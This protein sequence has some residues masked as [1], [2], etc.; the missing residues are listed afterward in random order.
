MS[1]G[2]TIQPIDNQ[3]QSQGNKYT[4]PEKNFSQKF[5]NCERCRLMRGEVRKTS[6]KVAFTLAEI[7]ITL[8]IIGVVAALTL[9]SVI[10]NYNERVTISKLK[11]LNST[12]QNSFNLMHQE[13][14]GGLDVSQWGYISRD[15]FVQ[16]YTKYMNVSKVCTKSNIYE[17]VPI[18]VY[19]NLGGTKVSLGL[20]SVSSG[21]VLNDGATAALV[22]F[23]ES[24]PGHIEATGVYGQIFV[25]VNGKNPPNVLGRDAFSFVF[26]KEG[27][28]PNGIVNLGGYGSS[29]YDKT[30]FCNK[31][32][33]GAGHSGLGCTA[34]V[35]YQ[36]NMDYLK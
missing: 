26:T 25:D 11:K 24:N 12:F 16:K 35:I 15:E 1:E 30:G 2:E 18:V 32:Y 36:E 29:R 27:V 7:L 3:K 14:F 20:S 9:P 22:W 34:W 4:F 8:G 31:N 17:C 5:M 19:S 28:K 33:T 23:A 13:E 10:N 21:F 6:R